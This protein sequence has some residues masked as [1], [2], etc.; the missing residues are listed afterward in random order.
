MFPKDLF[1]SAIREKVLLVRNKKQKREDH[2]LL[3]VERRRFQW[4]WSR[5][6]CCSDPCLPISMAQLDY[7][8]SLLLCCKHCNRFLRQSQLQ[9][10]C[11]M[12]C[13]CAPKLV[14]SQMKLKFCSWIE[15]IYH[16][17]LTNFRDQTKMLAVRW[18]VTFVQFMSHQNTLK[19]CYSNWCTL[20][21]IQIIN[22]ND[23][24]WV[25]DG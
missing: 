22:S 20:W 3:N 6:I 25:E 1:D 19:V 24:I 4:S 8:N 9:K 18:L 16:W 11:S 15:E 21:N 2:E 23:A 13:C 10:L 17:K 7:K 14:Q 12:R 5:T